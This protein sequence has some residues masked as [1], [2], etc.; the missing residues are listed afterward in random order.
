MPAHVLERDDVIWISFDPK[1]GRE[2]ADRRP[3]IVLSPRV[4]NTRAGLAIVC[5]VTAQA[6]DNR[7]R[8]RC[9]KVFR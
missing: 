4:D 5:P 9:R 1:V 6:R 2:Q 7:S 3:G 8:S